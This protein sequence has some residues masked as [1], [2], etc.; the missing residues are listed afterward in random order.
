MFCAGR[1]FSV[2]SVTGGWVVGIERHPMGSDMHQPTLLSF[3]V[4]FAKIDFSAST[5]AAFQ[6]QNKTTIMFP[7]LQTMLSFV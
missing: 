2:R 1:S 6:K 4:L 3:P 7:N 5:C